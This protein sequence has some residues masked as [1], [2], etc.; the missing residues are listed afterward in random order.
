MKS[1]NPAALRQGPSSNRTIALS[2]EDSNILATLR[3][4][5][6][7]Q[8]RPTTAAELLQVETMVNSD[9][10][11]RRV[12]DV[13]PATIDYVIEVQAAELDERAPGIDNATRTA[14]AFSELTDET[15]ILDSYQRLENSLQRRWERAHRN[16]IRLRDPKSAFAPEIEFCTNKPTAPES[17]LSPENEI[18]ANEPNQHPDVSTPDPAGPDSSNASTTAQP[19]DPK[20]EI[21]NCTI[22]PTEVEPANGL[23]L[24]RVQVERGIPVYKEHSL[25]RL[26]LLTAAERGSSGF[27]CT[28]VQVSTGDC[29]SSRASGR[30]EFAGP[31]TFRRSAQSS[32]WSGSS[33]PPGNSSG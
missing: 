12:W 13:E 2:V 27:P 26:Q 32:N 28:V 24:P 19:A 23:D 33:W 30:T 25:P 3:Q 29:V 14:F 9:W 18:G 7:R 22:E 1:T 11:L 31:E 4:D 5:Y 10:R 6:I 21:E 15:R 16:L 17:A 8:F 20:R